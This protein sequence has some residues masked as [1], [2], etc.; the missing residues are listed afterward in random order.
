MKTTFVVCAALAISPALLQAAPRLFVSTESL[1]PESEIELVLDQAAVPDSLVGKEATNEWLEVTPALPGKLLWKSPSTAR[2]LPDTPPTLDATYKF[3]VRGGHTY[4]DRSAV[5][6]G[7]IATVHADPFQV[8]QAVIV[9][10]YE[11]NYSPRTPKFYLRFNA[12]VD[13]PAAAQFLSFESKTGLK[14]AARVERATYATASRNGSITPSW[15]QRFEKARAKKSAEPATEPAP[16]TPVPNGLIVTPQTP[17]P[18]GEGWQLVLEKGLPD[19][20]NHSVFP[21]QATRW[22]GNIGAFAI[23]EIEAQTIANEPRQIS[24]SFSGNL[25]AKL[26]RESVAKYVSVTPEIPGMKAEV[27]GDGDLIL[28]GDF[29]ST[30]EWNVTIRPGLASADGLALDKESSKKITFE[31]LD[32]SIALTS[33]DEAQL[34]TGT[35]TYRIDTVNLSN[36]HVRVKQLSSTELLRALQGYRHYTGKGPNDETIKT[37]GLLPYELVA[38]TGIADLQLPACTK[39][40]TSKGITLKWD[41]MLPANTR[42]AALFL[43]ATGTPLEGPKEKRSPSTQAIIQLTDIG[44]AWKVNETDAHIYAFSCVTGEPLA[45]VNVDIFG[46]DAKPM[47]HVTTGATGLATVPRDK[48]A[49]HLRASLG[50]D[51][52]ATVFDTTL[53]TVGLWRFPVRF[54]WESIPESRRRAFLFSDRSLYR[55]GETVHVKGIVRNQNGNDIAKAGDAKARLVVVDPTDKEILAV[56]VTLSD[57]G[58]FDHTFQ[59]PAE[60]VGA[61]WVRLE[62][63][64]EIAKVEATENWSEKERIMST[65][66]FELRIRVEDFR[67]NAFEITHNLPQPEPGATSFS[68]EVSALYYQG[69]PVAKGK[70]SHNVRVSDVNLYPERFRDFLFGNHRTQDYTYWR[71]YFGFTWEDDNQDRSGTSLSGETELSADG[72][73]TVRTTLPEAKLPSGREATITTEVTDANHQTLVK[74]STVTIHPSSVYVGVSRLDQLVRVGD[75]VPLKLVA[76]TPDGEPYHD[77]LPVEAAITREVNEQVKVGTQPGASAVRNEA[78]EVPVSQSSLAIDPAGNDGK[79]TEMIFAPTQPGLHFL[80]VRGADAKGRAFATVVSFHVYGSNEYPWAYEDG[81]RIKLVAEKQQYQPG[82]TARVLVLSPIEGTALVTVE[83]EKVLRTFVTKLKA[84]KPLVEIPLGEDDAPNTYVSV[85]VIK[86]SQDSA[87]EFKE[88][89]LRLGYCEIKVEDRRHRLAVKLSASGGEDASDVMPVSTKEKSPP[90]LTARPGAEIALEGAVTT[91]DGKPAADSE[92]T[93][94][95]EDEGTLAVMGYDN[96]DPMAFFYDPRELLVNCGTSLDRFLPEAPE[97]QTFTNKGFFIGGGDGMETSPISMTRRDFNPC[98]VWVPAIRSDAQGHFKATCKLPDTLTRYRVI[99]VAQHEASEFGSSESA[100]VVNKPLMLEPHAPRFAYETDR[101]TPSL[102][103]QNG[104]RYEGTWKITFTPNPA[105]SSPVC[106]LAGGNDTSA[107]QTITLA[108]GGSSTVSFPVVFTD[109][110]EAVF[111][112]KAEPVSLQG[113]TITPG[114]A[115][116]LSDSVEARFQVQYPMPLLR[117][118]RLIKLDQPGDCDLLAS[119]DRTLL[120]GRGD[121]DLEISRSLLGEAGSAADFLLHYPYGCVEQTMSSTMPWLAVEPLR[122]YVPSFAKHTPEATRKA[123]QTGADR[124]LSMQLPDGGF[125]YW[126]GGK[127][128]LDW[129]TSYAGLGL[130]LTHK[131]GAKVPAAALDALV[132]DLE[133]SLRGAPDLKSSWHS[134]SV[135]RALWVLALADKPQIS[136]QNVLRERLSSLDGE[137]RCYL[138]L[139]IGASKTPTAK[140]DAL[141][142]LNSRAALPLEDDCWMP[143]RNDEALVLLVRATLDPGSKE[144]MIALDRLLKDRSP[145]G[146]WR[147]TWVNAWAML[148]MAECAKAEQAQDTPVT[149]TLAT[150]DGPSP[151]TLGSQAPTATRSFPLTP[152]LKLSAN[153]TGVSY[154][155]VKLAAKPAVCPMKPVATNGLEITRF[156]DRVKSDGSTE[157]MDKPAIGDLVRVTL[158]VTLPKDGERYL[159][160]EDPL[161]PMFEA[162]NS[163]FASQSAP[164][165]GATSENTWHVSHSELRNDRA[166]FFLDWVGTRGTY[167]VTYLARCT[168]AGEA[169]TPPAKVESMYDPDNTAL[170]ASRHLSTK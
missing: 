1:A 77:T 166:V 110:G 11:E 30:D 128:R 37:T 104:S 131:A 114:L 79:G 25:P 143:W 20:G 137:A 26:A 84:D 97:N 168:M 154:V 94:Y 153:S 83:R 21:N 120:E 138:A 147:T 76:V 2:F 6:A 27:N 119:L 99:A 80:T 136:Y 39:L 118:N 135:C 125:S 102:L 70:V 32:P 12:D 92:V 106:K 151:I 66:R 59:L 139:A 109:T 88:P 46:E 14:I 4:L 123:I 3:K 17:L 28:K 74:S 69:Q 111:T 31:N 127:E 43:E 159:V 144:T 61:H 57:M 95:A 163:D 34:A 116:K 48:E 44:L 8:E 58:S 18:V 41:A 52:F 45:G 155:R 24:V 100:I 158:R 124:L 121:I 47:N 107:S 91:S 15:T 68:T 156:Y 108:P 152:G 54:S 63:P 90:M 64:D 164:K 49:R 53:P 81:M 13:P 117:Q 9:G 98:A 67:R 146:H 132:K 160:V 65:A 23:K 167:S 112:W 134:E 5:P 140:K 169:E 75:R 51:S 16:E 149:V 36:V 85:L 62:Y 142:I 86:G 35:R 87:R 10:R 115:R 103:V 157:P 130:V 133:K 148:A 55:P 19:A 73:A 7:L 150:A 42:H 96:P 60:T 129:A 56:P 122:R 93:L 126:P 141:V 165:G 38:G 82:E 72:K 22:I 105:A 40:D 113:G 145:Y 170:S 89:Q 50:D 161:P 162:V 33:E 101:L 71:H 29:S 78:T